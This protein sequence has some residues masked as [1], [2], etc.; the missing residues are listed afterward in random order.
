MSTAVSE[1]PLTLY[2]REQVAEHNK[3]GDFWMIIN[4]EVY[5]VTEFESEHP[6]GGKVLLKVAGK[7]A[8]REF[9][10]YHR[11]AIL[12]RYKERLLIG[13]VNSEPPAKKGFLRRLFR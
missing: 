13:V 3:A 10:K 9:Q 2:S 1:K 8:T 12:Q 4:Q 5:D 6:G 7:D 11:N